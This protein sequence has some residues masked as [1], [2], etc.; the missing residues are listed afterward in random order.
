ML[1]VAYIT[2]S[3]ENSGV[4]VR[5]TAILNHL[6][7]RDDLAITVFHLDG[8]QGIASR[9]GDEIISVRPLP[10]ILGSKTINWIRLGRR[11]SRFLADFDVVHATNQTLSFIATNKPLVVT[12]HDIIELLEPQSG[13]GGWASRYLYSGISR[14][15]RLIAVSQYTARSVTKHLAVPPERITIAT[16]AA[17]SAF[18][19]I[20]D[21]TD[22]LGYQT[23][24]QEL[25]L[26]PDDQVILYVGSDHP[27]KNV[28]TALCTFAA[29]AQN[30]PDLVFIKMGRAGLQAGREETL[31]EIDRLGIRNT[32][33]VLDTVST[34]RLN[35]LYNLADVLLYPSSFEGFGLPPLQAMAAGT[36][37]VTSNA[38]SIPEVVGDAARV[39]APTDTACLTKAVT[40]ILSNPQIRSDMARAGI[41]QAQSFSWE[42][43]A[44]KVRA[45][46]DRAT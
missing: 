10:G 35:E 31:A 29:A 6:R 23:L 12:V 32:T 25:R 30:I 41:R 46:Y 4:G 45:V 42:T 26:K 40:D 9:D 1:K 39:C 18:T 17:G 43:S 37:V 20:P 14:A 19:L 38:T 2:N 16:N 7:E 8:E 11:L 34:Q 3:A 27:R 24:R 22:S 36:P 44:R 13:L 15:S 28:I 21:F 5:A 33:R